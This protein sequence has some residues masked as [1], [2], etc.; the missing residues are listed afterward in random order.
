M[1]V[2]TDP[3]KALGISTHGVLH[4]ADSIRS[5][6][7][8]NFC[9]LAHSGAEGAGYVCPSWEKVK[10]GHFQV[11]E[12]SRCLAGFWGHTLVRYTSRGVRW[13]RGA[14]QLLLGSAPF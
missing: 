4:K 10:G 2:S 12:I 9:K 5:L 3:Q 13:Q 1:Q 14:A 11:A 7:C 8:F 6:T